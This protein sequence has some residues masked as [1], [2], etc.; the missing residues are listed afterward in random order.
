MPVRSAE[1]SPASIAWILHQLDIGASA[2]GIEFLMLRCLTSLIIAAFAGACA[3][4]PVGQAPSSKNDIVELS[5]ADARDQLAAGTLTARAL[6]Q[7]YLDRIADVDDAGP[8]LNAVIELNP[9]ALVDAEALDAERTAG[10]LRGPLHGIP[11]LIKDN[12]DS[13]GMVNSA[14]SLALAEHR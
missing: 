12:I 7:A 14:G 8:Q 4:N 3:A 11:V 10:K 1:S 2:N 13:V 6:T 5:A 9:N